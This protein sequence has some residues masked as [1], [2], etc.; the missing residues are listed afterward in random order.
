[1]E[2]TPHRAAVGDALRTVGERIAEAAARIAGVAQRTNLVV[3][4]R[5]LDAAEGAAQGDGP[6]AAREARGL[7]GQM[8]EAARRVCAP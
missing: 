3:L 6:A 5:L 7:A 8:A 4:D 1:M 2:S